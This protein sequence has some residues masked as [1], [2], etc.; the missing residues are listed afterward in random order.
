MIYPFYV[1]SDIEGRATN[2]KGGTRRKDGSITTHIYQREEGSILESF[3]IKQTSAVLNTGERIL[4]TR[5]YDSDDI[6][7]AQ[8]ETIY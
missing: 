1:E 7:V 2:L 4:T 6:A 5:I 3:T 8:K